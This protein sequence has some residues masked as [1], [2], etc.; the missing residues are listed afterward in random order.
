ML[1]AILVILLLLAK[2]PVLAA[3]P[4]ETGQS[5]VTFSLS[6]GRLGD[7]LVAYMHA[8][9]FSFFHSVPLLLPGF[10][11][12]DQLMLHK[13]EIHYS[14]IPKNF[15][16]KHIKVTGVPTNFIPEYSTLY[17]I[18]YYPENPFEQKYFK[19][20]PNAETFPIDWDNP[21]FK[22]ELR[23]MIAPVNPLVLIPRP[24]NKLALAVHVRNNSNGFDGPLSFNRRPY[25]DHLFP[26]K[27][28]ANEFYISQIKELSESLGH[29]PLYAF[30]FTDD[31]NPSNIME[32]IKNAVNL[33][34]IEFDCRSAN[35]YKNTTLEDLFS[36]ATFDFLIRSDSNFAIVACKIS[37]SIKIEVFPIDVVTINNQKKIIAGKKINNI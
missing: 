10:P 16:K 14:T 11:Y 28:V 13:K 23:T 17:T 27:F 21:A 34:N 35:D 4:L 24:Q 18:P 32:N 33:N 1:K 36:M 26:S 9:T 6:G 20:V 15:F 12:A 2:V 5:A 37:T 30:I 7:N 25:A 8:K 29:P 3:S 31:A 19:Y 22:A